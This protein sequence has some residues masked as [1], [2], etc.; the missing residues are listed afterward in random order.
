MTFSPR[1][2]GTAIQVNTGMMPSRDNYAGHLRKAL[3]GTFIYRKASALTN[4]NGNG[5][6]A[7][8]PNSAAVETSKKS[9]SSSSSKNPKESEEANE[10]KN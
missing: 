4:S 5:E 8:F 6:M 2:T 10:W 9:S 7:T 1:T 3:E